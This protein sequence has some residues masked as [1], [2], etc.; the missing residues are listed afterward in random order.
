MSAF[1]Q[2][3]ANQNVPVNTSDQIV[4]TKDFLADP[5]WKDIQ[6]NTFRRWV[7]HNLKNSNSYL[8]SLEEGFADGLTL[9]KLCE[10]LS[11]KRLN[12]YNKK[13]AFK[14]QI[15]ENI[16]LALDFLQKVEGIKLVNI[17]S[18]SILEMNTKLTLGLVWT[19]I[20][21]YSI[22]KTVIE[23]NNL[24]STKGT[25]L[26][27]HQRLLS[28][29]RSKLPPDVP[30][31]NFTSD[32]NDGTALGALVEACAP[33]SNLGWRQ[34]NPKKAYE[35][36]CSAMDFATTFLGISDLL[37]AKELINPNVDEK[38]VMTFLS[39]FPQAKFKSLMVINDKIEP[40]IDIVDAGGRKLQYTSD[41]SLP[42]EF[43]VSFIPIATGNHQIDVRLLNYETQQT[44]ELEQQT[45]IATSGPKVKNLLYGMAVNQ[46]NKFQVHG[47][48]ENNFVEIHILDP[49]GNV[50]K[51][52]E[53][54]TNDPTTREF[55]F[56]SLFPGVYSVNVMVD[57][58][59]LPRSPFPVSCHI[60]QE[61][62]LYGH[63]LNEYAQRVGVRS[64]IF[65]ETN[66]HDD[67]LVDMYLYDPCK[68]E[69][70]LNTCLSEV[71]S[72]NDTILRE[73]HFY[74]QMEGTHELHIKSNGEHIA[75]SPYKLHIKSSV[76]SDIRA[77][78]PDVNIDGLENPQEQNIPINDFE[79]MFTYN[80]SNAG[81]AN[82]S[83]TTEDNEHIPYSP[84]SVRI[85]ETDE[86]DK[87]DG[88]ELS[89]DVLDRYPQ[90]NVG[91]PLV[92]K[93]FA[94][95]LPE[96]PQI[97]YKDPSHKVHPVTLKDCGND[98][99]ECTVKADQ[100]GNY[101]IQATTAKDIHASNSPMV[102]TAI[103]NIDMTKFR[104]YGPGVENNV[105][106]KQPTQ[107]FIDAKDVGPGEVELSMCDNAGEEINVDVID[108][109]DGSFT[110]KYTAPTPGDYILKVVFAGIEFPK[111]EINVKPALV[112]EG[113]RIVGLNNA[114][115]TVNTEKEVHVFTSNGEN[116][117]VVITSPSGL[118]VEALIEHTPNGLKVRFTP[119]EIGD[120]SIDVTYE[121]VSVED[122][123][124]LMR[125]VPSPILSASLENLEVDEFKNNQHESEY[126]VSSFSPPHAENVVVT[127]SGLGPIVLTN[128][129]ARILVNASDAGFDTIRVGHHINFS[130]ET[131]SNKAY[132]KG[133]Q[134]IGTKKEKNERFLIK[135][136][137]ED[138]TLTSYDA[139]F[140]SDDVGPL[141]FDVL[142][143]EVL[144]AHYFYRVIPGVDP[145]QVIANGDGIKYGI[146]DM[147]NYFQIDTRSSG[148]GSLAFQ[149]TGP[150]QS[151]TSVNDDFGGVCNFSY[152]PNLP[153]QYLLNVL[154]GP[155][156]I[157]INGSP[158][159]I[160]ADYV[161]N[162]EAIK[163]RGAGLVKARLGVLNTFTVD[164][165]KTKK[166]AVYVVPTP[167]DSVTI[168]S[169]ASKDDRF[170]TVQ[171]QIVKGKPNDQIKFDIIYGEETL[172]NSAYATIIPEIEPEKIKILA[173]NDHFPSALVAF[174][175]PKLYIDLQ[176]SGNIKKICFSILHVQTDSRFESLIE[177]QSNED[178]FNVCWIPEYSGDYKITIVCNNDYS[179]SDHVKTMD[180][181][182]NPKYD[183][184]KCIT[185][186]EDK[187][188]VIVDQVSKVSFHIDEDLP[189]DKKWF[190]FLIT[191]PGAHYQFEHD[192]NN[193]HTFNMYF[194]VFEPGMFQVFGYYGGSLIPHNGNNKYLAL[195]ND[196]QSND[197]RIS[198][199]QQ[200]H[201]NSNTYTGND[202]DTSINN[203]AA[204]QLQY[205]EDTL[206]KDC[207]LKTF[208][209]RLDKP[210]T[211][212]T[213]ALVT[214]PSGKVE[215]AKIIDNL[216]GT[217][218]VKYKAVSEGLHNL[219]LSHNG[220][221]IE[222]C[223]I[224]FYVANVG[225]EHVTVHGA[226][227][228]HAFVGEPAD[229]TVFAKN[230][231][232]KNLNITVEG[233]A[234]VNI[235]CVDNKN[236]SCSV[237]WTPPIAGEYKI[238]VKLAGKAIVGSPFTVVASGGVLQRSHFSVGS[239][240]EVNLAICHDDIRGISAVIKTPKGIEEPCVVKN[241][242]KQNISVSFVPREVGEHLISVYNKGILMRKNPF[243]IKVDTNQVGD[244]TKVKVTGAGIS[245]AISM[246]ENN[247]VIDTRNAG[248]GGISLSLVGPSK[249][250][251]VC[252]E[253]K[254]SIMTFGYTPN[255]PGVYVLTAKFADNQ[256]PGSPYSINCTGESL[257][258]IRST[259]SETVDACPIVYERTKTSL[260][261][262]VANANPMEVTAKLM[263]PNG[264]SEDIT[265]RQ[266]RDS[267]LYQIFFEVPTEGMYAISVFYKENHLRGGP[268]QFTCGKFKDQGIHRVR[269]IGLG[270]VRGE[271]N[272][273]N[274]I[275][276]YTRE[277]G[278]GKLD[279]SFDGPSKADLKLV[280]HKSG[281]HELQYKV[282]KSGEYL[283]G[284]K[285]NNVHIPE[286]PFK[287]FVAASTDQSCLLELAGFPGG[288]VLI[289]KPCTFNLLTHNAKGNI[290]AQLV[291]PSGSTVPIDMNEIDENESYMLRFIPK[292]PGN[293][294]VHITL[295]GAPMHD[296][297]FRVR[298]GKAGEFDPSVIH[299]T[300]IGLDGGE[301]GH[302]CEFLIRT[303]NA[304]A[305][306]LSINVDG[307]SKVSLDA[308]EVRTGYKTNFTAFAPGDYYV[309]VKYNGV[310]IPCSPY[311]IVIKG[312]TIAKEV[313][314]ENASL[315]IAAPA[316]TAFGSVATAPEYKGDA[317]KVNAHGPGL[318]KFFPGRVA[319]FTVD[320]NIAGPNLL[321]IA[322]C[323]AKGLCEE[324]SVKQLTKGQ[325]TVNYKIMDR[326]RAFVYIKYG[327][328]PIPGSP[329][330]INF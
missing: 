152:V 92:L 201:H 73:F 70:L 223:P 258:Q 111:I 69:Q 38:S 82:I 110:V 190:D 200:Q 170:Y 326:Q 248:Y 203:N 113:I 55:S 42:T 218:T 288:A 180:F 95:N 2:S 259:L 145:M 161:D 239:T 205:T 229:F 268:Y 86:Y 193:K 146:V 79:T 30:V 328:T 214:M 96:S 3:G 245:R 105:K 78:G 189:I 66:L 139:L 165:R 53:Y 261:L 324:I 249:S 54:D 154:Y 132:G 278:S 305:G 198:E 178:L 74:P 303:S 112:P 87:L 231:I 63:G 209:V 266:L 217:V 284:I 287:V 60:A 243:K 1:P 222:G 242:D 320:T 182:V 196:S 16:S 233:A 283:I 59:Q 220:E 153:G 126:V 270:L 21:H 280:D 264:K 322:V 257:G 312:P 128:K 28:W 123:P 143:D 135:L 269:A 147:E 292:E 160:M 212:H 188:V 167:T 56:V 208:T 104:V 157:P 321:Y 140:I 75:D 323:T 117:R 137:T 202:L 124:F 80:P 236:G 316:K 129:S 10:I 230:S 52:V 102:L 89:L 48:S 85:T 232:A 148:K 172:L 317:K 121:D 274:L 39:Q 8:E 171:Y 46:E 26:T 116:T 304:G 298:V 88:G 45:L 289:N 43:D 271:T 134:V 7:N 83:I 65:T 314:H 186:F 204:Y 20:L 47:L 40:H 31:T 299:L 215:S 281:C 225:S 64:T 252:K 255:E 118:V 108:N 144:I 294:F 141:T 329:F 251:I 101:V 17:D 97:I 267:H 44:L 213:T 210:L 149:I 300:G 71:V 191:S 325:Y 133:L 295:D 68:S 119:S 5:S 93:L 244:A 61:F 159:I 307:P 315:V 76:N 199:N 24:L 175:D 254:N 318:V 279:V 216:D 98:Y 240:S 57:K 34:F 25:E 313:Q 173:G 94:K 91:E 238:N 158:F 49:K 302:P 12:S 115:V 77:Q 162:K 22:G 194:K 221:I 285:W 227:L 138:V 33:G 18:H 67:L 37:T 306:L 235:K 122:S 4:E 176:E 228:T 226:G 51:T 23:N 62:L 9:I 11:G 277:A 29:I 290:E 265:V 327:D 166:K 99:Y 131:G 319:N 286:S 272:V 36:T 32:W 15:L 155:D 275:N 177:K 169:E 262:A 50:A 263:H 90:L 114:I 156:K 246:K 163:I 151:T 241:I 237:T 13:V 296:S 81:V 291:V 100:P 179:E 41:K 185:K 273:N 234:K 197:E 195:L 310:H 164:I 250:Q 282:P 219:N 330:A 256:I 308:Y 103:Q 192:L 58:R 136:H 184:S 168:Y 301:T 107:F 207:L 253:N 150:S 260:I 293:Y 297:P 130:I 72:T 125:S 174:E 127:G 19:L 14:A 309:S 35:N 224:N 211:H 206:Y 181:Y 106:A 183:V 276:I 247:F 84:F 6:L 27:P 109:D 187:G 120:Y 142:F 311:K